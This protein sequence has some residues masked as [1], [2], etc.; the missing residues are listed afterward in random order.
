MRFKMNGFLAF[1]FVSQL[2]LGQRKFNFSSPVS[3]SY[4]CSSVWAKTNSKKFLSYIVFCLP[5]KDGRTD[6]F[7]IAHTQFC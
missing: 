5:I 2:C 3:R 4:Q 6:I 7:N 1:I